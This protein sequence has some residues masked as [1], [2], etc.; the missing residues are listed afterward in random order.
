MWTNQYEK[1]EVPVSENLSSREEWVEQDILFITNTLNKL[2]SYDDKIKQEGVDDL[3]YILPIFLINNLKGE[4]LVVY[5]KAKLEAAK[6]V[7][8]IK[9]IEK[10]VTERLKAKA[11]DEEEFVDLKDTKKKEE[12]KHMT[13][14]Q[15]LE[16]PSEEKKAPPVDGTPQTPIKNN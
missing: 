13:M 1:G 7:K 10:N 14:E 15:E 6:H 5:L 8:E 11:Q 9:E 3:G 12:A 2:M 16:M 4:E